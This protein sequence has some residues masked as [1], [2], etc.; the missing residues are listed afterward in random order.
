MTGPNSDLFKRDHQIKKHPV[1]V[2]VQTTKQF[3]RGTFHVRGVMRVI[4][5]LAFED[6]FIALT[7]ADIYNLNG[8]KLLQTEFVAVNRKEIVWM[9]PEENITAQQGAEAD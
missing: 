8:K 4:D 7:D 5:E 9:G 1:P 6:I 3:I 2:A